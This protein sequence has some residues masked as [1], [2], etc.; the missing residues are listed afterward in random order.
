MSDVEDHEDDE[1]RDAIRELR[2]GVPV[3][4]EWRSRVL[5]AVATEPRP[6]RAA[7]R[8][9]TIRW[10]LPALAVAATLVFGIRMLLVQQPQSLG[11]AAGTQPAPV[12]AVN[13]ESVRFSLT[14]KAS[15]VSVVGDFNGWD[16]AALP[17]QRSGDGTWSA[18]VPISHGRHVY[19]FVVDGRVVPDPLAPRAAEDDYGIPNSVVMVGGLGR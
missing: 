9:S 11:T 13:R 6:A 4:D 14:T 3:R 18:T 12:V 15:A 10:V 16:P 7:V 5:E 8:R 17:L 1:M 2:A 19:A